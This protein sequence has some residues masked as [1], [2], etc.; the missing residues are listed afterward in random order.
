MVYKELQQEGVAFPR[1]FVYYK[2]TEFDSMKHQYYERLNRIG[3]NRERYLSYYE[4]ILRNGLLSERSYIGQDMQLLIRLCR[5]GDCYLVAVSLKVI[6]ETIMND[7]R[8]LPKLLALKVT[9]VLNPASQR[10]V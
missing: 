10:V 6:E 7:S 1:S 4:Q 3:E 9:V 5:S 2:E 8:P